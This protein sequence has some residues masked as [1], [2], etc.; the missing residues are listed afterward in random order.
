MAYLWILSSQAEEIN[1]DRRRK[2][3]T[4]IIIW[5]KGI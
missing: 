4:G 1:K 3:K 2:N 5:K